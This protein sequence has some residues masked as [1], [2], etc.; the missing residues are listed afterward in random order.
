MKVNVK[1]ASA[2]FRKQ[3]VHKTLTEELEYLLSGNGLTRLV[4]LPALPLYTTQYW[5]LDPTL[6]EARY[7]SD[8]RLIGSKCQDLLDSIMSIKPADRLDRV[9]AKY[10]KGVLMNLVRHLVSYDIVPIHGRQMDAFGHEIL[11]EMVVD[12]WAPIRKAWKDVRRNDIFVTLPTLALYTSQYWFL[13][14][15]L[16]EPRYQSDLR[17]I[18]DKYSTL[19]DSVMSIK[20][21]DRLEAVRKKYPEGVLR[22]LVRHLISH[23][24]IPIHG[25]H[26][27]VFTHDLLA[28]MI[29]DRWAPL[30][31]PF[32]E[33]RREDIFDEDDEKAILLHSKKRNE[34]LEE[35]EVAT[36]YQV[37]GEDG[38]WR[39]APQ[40]V[41][42][43][44]ILRQRERDAVRR[45]LEINGVTADEEA[46]NLRQEIR[47][48]THQH[49]L[50]DS[51]CA[52]CHV[53][54]TKDVIFHRPLDEVA[55]TGHRIVWSNIAFDAE[56]PRSEGGDY[57]GGNLQ[58]LCNGCN[59]KKGRKSMEQARA[60][61]ERLARTPLAVENG[62]LSTPDPPRKVLSAADISLPYGTARNMMMKID[63]RLQD[64]P[65]R[66]GDL[67]T[68]ALVE[69]LERRYLGEGKLLCVGGESLPLDDA[70]PDRIDPTGPYSISNT[71]LTS[72]WMNM[73]R[74]N[75]RD[76]SQPIGYREHLASS[77]P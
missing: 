46:R 56:V 11:A 63:S 59:M 6:R 14:P 36:K 34:Y 73:L 44:T 53:V 8:L 61:I 18:E 37:Q 66:R 67:T 62:F 48:S 22:N 13:D 21:S 15:K 49:S 70:S 43:K 71:R 68:R 17:L 28:E 41:K 7:Q 2:E 20:P 57:T 35:N 42:P 25:R 40:V 76:D 5:F 30:Y 32:E 69:K 38:K 10:P 74:S 39:H 75:Q 23:D 77:S 65:D 29:E 16:R 54:M 24:I 12:R 47:S 60:E 4:T 19:M 64:R 33:V 27:D 9:R 1:T 58:A 55:E 72:W 51:K 50:H 3:S 31:K 52:I 26:M 45:Q